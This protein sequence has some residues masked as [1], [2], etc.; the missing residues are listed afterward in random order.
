M[1]EELDQMLAPIAH[2]GVVYE[3]DLGKK[4]SPTARG[5]KAFDPGPSW[6]KV[7]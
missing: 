3:K 2:D 1:Q 5:M 6:R 4:T 7:E